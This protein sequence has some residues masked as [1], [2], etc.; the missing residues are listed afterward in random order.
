MADGLQEAVVGHAAPRVG[1]NEALKGAMSQHY[2]YDC[3]SVD[4]STA[5]VHPRTLTRPSLHMGEAAGV[6]SRAGPC[7]LELEAYLERLGLGSGLG[8]GLGLGLG[9]GL[10]SGFGST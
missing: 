1:R 8:S 4:W 9:L 6:S 10:G 3:S 5:S 7:L 2:N